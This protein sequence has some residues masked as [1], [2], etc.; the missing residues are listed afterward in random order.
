M[1]IEA[2]VP[3]PA[4]VKPPSQQAKLAQEAMHKWSSASDVKSPPGSPQRPPGLIKS[5]SY[6]PSFDQS[7]ART[8]GL[9]R[10][11]S[12]DPVQQAGGS[13][14][15]LGGAGVNPPRSPLTRPA[16]QGKTVP[17]LS[18]PSSREQI[19]SEFSSNSRS[20][21]NVTAF[22][23]H[24]NLSGKAVTRVEFQVNVDI[25]QPGDRVVVTGSGFELGS[26]QPW[27]AVELTT[28]E[29]RYP[30]WTGVAALP[31]G[32][33]LVLSPHCRRRTI[34]LPA[35]SGADAE[36]VC[37]QEYKYVIIRGGQT[38]WED[39]IANRMCT[40]EGTYL[41]LEDGAFNVER[42]RLLNREFQSVDKGHGRMGQNDFMDM[43]AVSQTQCALS[44]ARTDEDLFRGP[45][46]VHRVHASPS[47]LTLYLQCMVVHR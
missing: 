25:T 47:V 19:L 45:D 30:L 40:A 4:L 29:N 34:T 33:S 35:M 37:C 26:W 23:Q 44:F 41:V 2:P 38:Q 22:H 36:H 12:G 42:A 24:G 46:R 17:K 21:T 39:A 20:V 31:S 43:E 32:Q 11:K 7:P 3:L 14:N 16:A 13:S 5:K 27:N 6:E 15:D 28:D 1:H 8:P 18:R 10:S 9:N